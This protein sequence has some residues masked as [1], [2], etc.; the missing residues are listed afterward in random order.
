MICFFAPCYAC[1][2]GYFSSGSD[3]TLGDY[4]GIDKVI[5]GD[6]D[7]GVSLMILHNREKISLNPQCVIGSAKVEKII[8]FNKSMFFSSTVPRERTFFFDQ[9]DETRLIPLINR[10]VHTIEKRK[11][12]M[13][14]KQKVKK[15]LSKIL[16][17]FW[18]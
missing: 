3:V 4:W 10:C 14:K 5:R 1:P 2:F 17:K 11:S 15:L 13:R 18:G 7:T 16:T 8:K 9:L 6:D 12:I